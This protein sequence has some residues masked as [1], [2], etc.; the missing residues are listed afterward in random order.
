MARPFPTKDS[1]L[2]DVMLYV[3]EAHGEIA[4]TELAMRRAS[5]ILSA[6][7]IAP[8]PAITLNYM[9]GNRPQTTQQE[10]KKAGWEYNLRKASR[11]RFLACKVFYDAQLKLLPKDAQT[12]KPFQLPETFAE[13][14]LAMIGGEANIQE[15]A[16]RIG[17]PSVEMRDFAVKGRIPVTRES[18]DR[19]IENLEQAYPDEAWLSP[20]LRVFAEKHMTVS[21]AKQ[22]KKANV[23]L[24]REAA[25]EILIDARCRMGLLMSDVEKRM[26]DAMEGKL[27]SDDAVPQALT[28]ARVA[29]G[30]VR[31]F[32]AGE[33]MSASVFV[34]CIR[35]F[36]TVMVLERNNPKQHKLLGFLASAISPK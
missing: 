33:K 7:K 14:V 10:V 21:Q 17:I 2:K 29:L 34:S 15:A 4:D 23:E 6:G 22:G 3:L 26:Q 20:L 12:I 27:K 8:W 24:F 11:Q 30:K 19:F 28:V 1:T 9:L 5:T 13:T 16:Q 35:S 25:R 18:T 32:E 36:S 31:A